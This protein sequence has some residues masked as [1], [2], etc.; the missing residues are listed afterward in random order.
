MI[1]PNAVGDTPFRLRSKSRTPRAA[2]IP[3]MLLLKAGWLM[4]SASA[5]RAK[6]RKR[7]IAVT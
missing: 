3:R 4:P 2:S 5:A 6:L 7:P 1:S